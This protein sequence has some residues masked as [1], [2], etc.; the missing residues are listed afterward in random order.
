MYCNCKSNKSNIFKDCC[1]QKY[2]TKQKQ[3]NNT[4][5]DFYRY[6]LINIVKLESQT[7]NTGNREFEWLRNK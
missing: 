4:D 1:Y 6:L 3:V 7:G 5:E 2:K